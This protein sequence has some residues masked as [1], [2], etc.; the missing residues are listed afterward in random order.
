[1]QV[2]SGRQGKNGNTWRSLGGCDLLGE[3]AHGL[4]AAPLITIPDTPYVALRASMVLPPA[5]P[6]R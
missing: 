5:A 3:A 6:A 1:M 4:A 2:P